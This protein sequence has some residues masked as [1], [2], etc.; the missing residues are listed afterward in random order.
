[1][2]VKAPS[3]AIID[4]VLYPKGFMSPWLKCV[5]ETKGKEA[6]QESHFG[7][8]GAHE[9]ERALTRKIFR[10]GIYWP[11]I[12]QN[13]LKLTRKCVKCQTYSPIQRDP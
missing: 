13:A 8:A 6:L 11:T 10:T 1:M 4:G 9:G 12:H 5:E 3:Y 2:R 7:L